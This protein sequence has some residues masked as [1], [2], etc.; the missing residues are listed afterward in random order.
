MVF[1]TI[2]GL[3][4]AANLLDSLMWTTRE[5]GTVCEAAIAMNY[6]MRWLTGHKNA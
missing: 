6:L 2:M 5:E 3:S 1:R 4:H